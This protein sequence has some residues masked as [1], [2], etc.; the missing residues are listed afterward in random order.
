LKRANGQL[1]RGRLG[2]EAL[3]EAAEALEQRS[4]HRD[5]ARR[6]VGE[7]Q[8]CRRSL[9]LEAVVPPQRG[10]LRRQRARSGVRFAVAD[11]DS[12][13]SAVALGVDC[14]RDRRA[15]CSSGI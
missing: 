8:G 6:H 4:W 1:V 10:Q 3:V 14:E 13:A 12:L 2:P 9:R 11:D 7:R 15:A 5:V